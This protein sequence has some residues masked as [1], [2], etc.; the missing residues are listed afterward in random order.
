MRDG[1]IY[2]IIIECKMQ[3][4]WNQTTFSVIVEYTFFLEM[5]GTHGTKSLWI[6]VLLTNTITK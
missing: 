3:R 4:I 6:S 2:E 5:E 1:S